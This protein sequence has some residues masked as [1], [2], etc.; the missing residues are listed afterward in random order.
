[1]RPPEYIFLQL[2]TYMYAGLSHCRAEISSLIISS[3]SCY[4]PFWL[5]PFVFLKYEGGDFPDALNY[6]L[7]AVR[8]IGTNARVRQMLFRA[9][10]NAKYRSY[11]DSGAPLGTRTPDQPDIS[12]VL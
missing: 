4:Q 12:R 8:R 11:T 3:S 7:S 9:A 6:P 10:S 2:G 5:L 1:M